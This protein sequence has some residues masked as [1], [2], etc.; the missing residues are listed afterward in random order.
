MSNT[1][2]SNTE[3]WIKCFGDMDK[4][5][6]NDEYYN[7]I[8]KNGWNKDNNFMMIALRYSYKYKS[9][10]LRLLEFMLDNGFPLYN[11]GVLREIISYHTNS[12]EFID[13]YLNRGLDFNDDR[14]Y[15]PIEVEDYNCY[16]Y[17]S[18]GDE[19]SNEKTDE[20][21]MTKPCIRFIYQPI[22]YFARSIPVIKKIMENGKNK[23]LDLKRNIYS[24]EWSAFKKAIDYGDMDLVNFYM[25]YINEQYL[26]NENWWEIMLN[27]V[28]QDGNVGKGA[29]KCYKILMK[30]EEMLNTQSKPN[31]KIYDKVKQLWHY[32]VKE[33][34]GEFRD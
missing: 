17:E 27:H 19:E 13:I 33:D 8:L 9:L 32:T 23:D 29:E 31:R 4:E 20:C 21:D 25:E 30:R 16:Y 28:S 11:V 18:S 7:I 26:N 10:F 22:L 3:M 24:E 34:P 15:E 12:L 5:P 1:E 2:M 14:L 6:N